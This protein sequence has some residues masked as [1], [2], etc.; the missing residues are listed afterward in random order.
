M[1]IDVGPNIIHALNKLAHALGIAADKVFPFYVKH[2]FIVGVW[3][4]LLGYG[5]CIL[6]SCITIL[7][8]K[9]TLKIK[10]KRRRA[11]TLFWTFF[12]AAF[13]LV[14]F[15]CLGMNTPEMLSKTFNPEYHAMHTLMCDLSRLR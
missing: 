8:F 1:Q 12:L 3:S 14:I 9:K 13:V 2:Y 15:A 4:L 5:A 6:L 7:A 10:D 11:D